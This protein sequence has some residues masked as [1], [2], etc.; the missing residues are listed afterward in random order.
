MD[1]PSEP[2]APRYHEPTWVRA[3]DLPPRS[4][5][6]RQ[7]PKLKPGELLMLIPPGAQLHNPKRA[8]RRRLA[9][10]ARGRSWRRFRK[11]LNRW[12]A[13]RVGMSRQEFKRRERAGERP[14]ELPPVSP[15]E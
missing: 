5:L 2:K 12:R 11:G 14:D 13:A 1:N 10:G 6:Q 7:W 8:M 3:E 15:P 9:P 4:P